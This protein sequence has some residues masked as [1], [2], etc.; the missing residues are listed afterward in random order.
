LLYV[1]Q[2]YLVFYST[3]ERDSNGPPYPASHMFEVKE[4]NGATADTV[5][6]NRKP[7][8]QDGGRYTEAS[9]TFER[10]EMRFQLLP[11]T[12]STRPGLDGAVDIGRH[13]PNVGSLLNSKCRP[14]KPEVEITIDR[15]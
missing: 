13:F 7:A 3:Q 8:I 4:S 6:C 10:L 9:I 11:P 2:T 5:T 15:N 12:F 1:P 14:R